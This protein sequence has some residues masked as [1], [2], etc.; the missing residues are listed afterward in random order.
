MCVSVEGDGYAPCIGYDSNPVMIRHGEL[1][2]SVPGLD[3]HWYTDGYG[4]Q[5]D[6]ALTNVREDSRSGQMWVQPPFCTFSC[7]MTLPY[8]NRE[9]H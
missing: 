7:H 3:F 2:N 1:T 5:G 6:G 9:P 4:F 8:Y